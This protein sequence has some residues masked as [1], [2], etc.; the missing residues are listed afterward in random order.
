LS[1]LAAQR[2]AVV[3]LSTLALAG[4]AVHSLGYRWKP[5]DL[6]VEGLSALLDRLAEEQAS[7]AG[8]LRGARTGEKFASFS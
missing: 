6:A 2:Q 5:S 4:D 3:D 1:E 8:R 7:E